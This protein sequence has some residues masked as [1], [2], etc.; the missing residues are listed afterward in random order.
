MQKIPEKT[1]FCERISHHLRPL[2][3]AEAAAH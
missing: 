1:P 2:N 3:E